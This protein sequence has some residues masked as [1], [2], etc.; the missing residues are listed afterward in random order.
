MHSS[1]GRDKGRGDI[2]Q[3]TCEDMDDVEEFA[4]DAE[5]VLGD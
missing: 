4:E 3:G 1:R 2:A 5:E